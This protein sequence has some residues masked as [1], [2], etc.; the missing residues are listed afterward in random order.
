MNLQAIPLE[1]VFDRVRQVVPC[2]LFLSYPFP[3]LVSSDLKIKIKIQFTFHFVTLGSMLHFLLLADCKSQQHLLHGLTIY[4]VSK[5]RQVYSWLGFCF[6]FL[7]P[8]CHYFFVGI[9]KENVQMNSFVYSTNWSKG[10]CH[11][12]FFW[13]KKHIFIIP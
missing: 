10:C 4:C 8:H 3:Q 2:L 7:W 1:S 9:L 11:F 6:F 5:Q 13:R 12:I